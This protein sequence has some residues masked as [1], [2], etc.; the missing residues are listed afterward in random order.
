MLK[1]LIFRSIVIMGLVW[2]LGS[3]SRAQDNYE[4]SLSYRVTADPGQTE[5]PVY[6]VLTTPTQLGGVDVFLQYDRSLMA[7]SAVNW[8]MRF[9]Y[10]VCDTSLTGK[11]RIGLRRHRADSTYIT[12]IPAGTDTLGVVKMT[13][14]TADLLTDVETTVRFWENPITPQ[15]DNRLTKVDSTFVVPPALILREGSVVIRHPLYGDVNDDGYPSTIADVIFFVNYLVG[16]QSFT[17]RQ[18]A[19][20]DVNQDGALGSM[21]DFVDLIKKVTAD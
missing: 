5:V 3:S 13:V 14:F 12:S 6:L 16:S 2:G 20:S 10:I 21:A 18:R 4:L 17:P 19:N 11:I 15:E 7:C 1:K 9:Q 8:L